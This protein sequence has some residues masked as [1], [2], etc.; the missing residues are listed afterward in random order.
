MSIKDR[1]M[2]VV[3]GL[4]LVAAVWCVILVWQTKK[5]KM[6]ANLAEIESL[7]MPAITNSIGMKLGILVGGEFPMGS[8]DSDGHADY[9]ER[10]QHRVRITK[11]FLL[12]V[13]E[14]TV[15]QFGAFVRSTNYE[16]E[17][18]RDG[19]GGRG[20]NEATG[21]F[22]G[23]DPKYTWRNTGFPQSDDHPVVNV[24]W[25]DA[26]A[27]CEWL[28][29][30]EGFRYR[31]PTEAEWEYACRAGTTSAYQHG[32]DAEGLA[33]VGNVADGTAKAMWTNYQNFAY[34]TASDG[35]AFTSPVGRYHANAL[36]LF[37]MHGNVWEW[38]SDWFEAKYHGESPV[39]D[40]QGPP[41]G[42]MR[43]L[44]GGGWFT[45]ASFCRS[46]YRGEG[47]ASYRDKDLG[48]RVVR[49]I[50]PSK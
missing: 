30:K 42:S 49:T 39:V 21:M 17:A 41:K 24:T 7:G 18:E 12:G 33:F 38:C 20:W 44:R 29:G 5:S 16:T 9:R 3:V 19:E 23:R 32:D 6:A 31:L 47:A 34:L 10:P 26:V 46:A 48:F 27:F 45:D 35:H 2:S 25:N 28:S 11:P 22:E 13:Y 8:P 40:P 4:A 15:G 50:A 37:D 14:V 43:A 36:G 1:I